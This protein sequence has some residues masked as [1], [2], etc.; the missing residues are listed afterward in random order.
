MMFLLFSLL[1]LSSA[2]PVADP[3]ASVLS[4][5]YDAAPYCSNGGYCLPPVACAPWY[6]NTLYDPSAACY[7]APGTPGV[8]CP[9]R[10]SSCK[11]SNENLD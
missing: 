11:Y 4:H 5:A 1:S 2:T 10:K 7:L 8:C 3:E 6:L 9:P